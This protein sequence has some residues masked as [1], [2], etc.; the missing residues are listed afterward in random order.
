MADEATIQE[1]P[2][3]ATEAPPEPQEAEPSVDAAE[4][5]AD[6]LDSWLESRG[7]PREALEA[8][9]A[10]AEKPVEEKT[11]PETAD[12]EPA[13]EAAPQ[14]D[15]DILNEALDEIEGE[16]KTGGKEDA[17]EG[18]QRRASDRETR[19][20]Q[21]ENARLR[22][23]INVLM[24]GLK[25]GGQQAA[26]PAGA[27]GGETADPSSEEPDMF[28]DPAGWKEWFKQQTVGPL[29]DRIESL[30]REAQQ[31]RA[32]NAIRASQEAYEAANPGYGARLQAHIDSVVD[33]VQYWAEKAGTE[34]DPARAREHAVGVQAKLMREGLAMWRATNGAVSPHEYVD[35]AINRASGFDPPIGVAAENG[36]KPAVKPKPKTNRIATEQAASASA[37]AGSLSDG[38]GGGESTGGA[39]ALIASEFSSDEVHRMLASGKKQDFFDALREV[40]E[41]DEG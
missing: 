34:V 7:V 39:D 8:S 31:T 20:L 10:K 17:Q 26:D 11:E 13:Q 4:S 3:Q 5:E 25:R 2:E 27:P 24:D 38:S 22:E 18:Y 9:R 32:R 12:E 29:E 33:E 14:T 41:A 21:E 19:S 37:A 23:H 30:T 35:R 15:Y 1:Q 28:E 6:M 16:G 40:E 36:Q